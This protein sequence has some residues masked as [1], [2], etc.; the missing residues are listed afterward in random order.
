MIV[1]RMMITDHL[2]TGDNNT[3][4]RDGTLMMRG[5]MINQDTRDNQGIQGN[6]ALTIIARE[7][8]TE[9]VN[10]EEMAGGKTTG[11]PVKAILTDQGRIMITPMETMELLME[12]DMATNPAGEISPITGIMKSATRAG[13][14]GT[15]AIEIPTGT[16]TG[17][18]Q[19]VVTTTEMSVTGGTEHLMKY[20]HGLEM[21]MQNAAAGWTA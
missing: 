14:A 4:A 1:T 18:T 17:T 2:I 15:G 7:M 5:M 8:S 13:T 19:T 16:R 21:M 3:T 10:T 20:P 11:S 9:A 12:R 6:G